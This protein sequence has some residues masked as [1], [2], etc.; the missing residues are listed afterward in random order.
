[1]KEQRKRAISSM[2]GSQNGSLGSNRVIFVSYIYVE[3]ALD[4]LLEYIPGGSLLSLVLKLKL[5]STNNTWHQTIYQRTYGHLQEFDIFDFMWE[6]SSNRIIWI[7]K[8]VLKLFSFTFS[9]LTVDQLDEIS[10]SLDST[11]KALKEA[12]DKLTQKNTIRMSKIL[13]RSSVD[14]SSPTQAEDRKQK[15]ATK[16]EVKANVTSAKNLEKSELITTAKL[17]KRETSA[18]K[19]K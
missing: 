14:N 9:K 8:Q 4:V 2:Y 17:D 7:I 16:E 19:A 13:N 1:M 18:K 3:P 15:T 10:E 5:L 11:S 12:K 6:V